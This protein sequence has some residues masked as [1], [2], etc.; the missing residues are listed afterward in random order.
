MMP[1]ALFLTAYPEEDASCRYRVHQ[2]LPYLDQAGYECTV[3]PFASKRLFKLLKTQGGL[4]RKAIEAVRSTARRFAIVRKVGSYDLVVIHR[5]VFP[6]FAPVVEN[7]VLRRAKQSRRRTRVI[8]SFDDA[9]Y[10]GHEDVSSL[11][12]PVLYR[13]KHGRG[14]DEVIRGCDHVIAG[15]RILADH[16]ARFNASVTVIPTAVDCAKYQPRQV[17]ATQP[18]PITIGWMGSPTT[19]PYLRLVAPALQCVAAKH[20][21]K[22][23]FRFVGCPEYK[24]ELPNFTSVPFRLQTEIEELK[25]FDIGLMPLIDSAW[26]RGKCAFK[27][28]QY[29]ASGV[30]TVASPVGITPDLIHDGV[31]GVLAASLEDWFRTLDR[32][33]TD[34]GW[35]NRIAREARR[36]IETGYSIETWAPR[37]VALFDQLSGRKGILEQDT[38]AA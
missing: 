36:S 38:I 34:A 10:A 26:T 20:A 13:W 5:E 2:F 30:A 32:L 24:L 22:V 21:D 23:H 25:Q 37:M 28:V 11:S 33:I 4:V 12:H 31:N 19:A 18:R 14:Y 16:A 17:D 27:A 7:L 6:F 3:A 15:N 1:R 29:M 35:R 9:L 8:F